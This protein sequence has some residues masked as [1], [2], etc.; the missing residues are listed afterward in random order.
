MKYIEVTISEFLFILCV[1]TCPDCL[2]EC[3]M[4]IKVCPF[5]RWCH[6]SAL[7]SL[8][9]THFLGLIYIYWFITV[10]KEIDFCHDHYNWRH[11]T[12]LSNFICPLRN[13]FQWILSVR[14]N[15]DH[16]NICAFI[17]DLT[18]NS[19]VFITTSIVNLNFDLFAFDSF[20]PLINIKYRWFII[21]W[22]GIIEIITDK[23]RLSYRGRTNEH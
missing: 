23:T 19:K 1:I 13:T 22:E 20:C 14:C 12:R 9:F 17:L 6:N 4:N 2:L 15:T 16:E 10:L 18:I 7:E 5:F 21:L 8:F 11:R 3:F